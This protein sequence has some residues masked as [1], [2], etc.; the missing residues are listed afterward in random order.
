MTRIFS[1][2]ARRFTDR[3]RHRSLINLERLEPRIAMDGDG[4]VETNISS[5]YEYGRAIEL[6]ADGQL[7]A[8]GFAN[9]VT[10]TKGN[11]TISQN[12]GV[13]VRY[14]ADGSLDSALS[15]DGIQTT[16]L[17]STQDGF[18]DLAI[19][20]DQKIVAAGYAN[21]NNGQMAVVRYLPN[22][23]LDPSFDADGKAFTSFPGGGRRDTHVA[24]QGFAVGLQP[25][26]KIVV[27][28]RVWNFN[29]GSWRFG[30]ARFN[31]NGS[32]DTTFA[33]TGHVITDFGL[34][35]VGTD[36][37]KI[38]YE[39][40]A[41]ALQGDGKIIAAGGGV[42][43]FLM[44]RYNADGTL[45]HSFDGD[46]LIV[47]DVNSTSGWGLIGDVALQ[48]DGK[49]V[50]V[51]G[52]DF[53]AQGI[54]A[55]YNPDGSLDSAFG[56]G[57]LVQHPHF[58]G[59]ITNVELQSDGKIV[60][61]GLRDWRASRLNADGSLDT[62]FAGTGS[63]LIASGSNGADLVIQPN[64]PNVPHDDKFVLIAYGENGNNFI[65]ARLNSDGAF[66]STWGDSAASASSSSLASTE[67]TVAPPPAGGS[68]SIS[69]LDT[70]A[71][72]QLFAEPEAKN[73]WTR[74]SRFKL[75][76]L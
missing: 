66:D 43:Y 35:L 36:G 2:S 21:V 26:Q 23:S 20:G 24:A 49:I 28:G 29:T 5:S 12:D 37:Q 41:V 45:D 9:F 10:T 4:I 58:A 15:G 40:T 19:Q 13:L 59:T 8:A 17:G 57:G 18:W 65:V 47:R 69:A 75:F 54:V 71:V 74:K 46:G 55:R 31:S 67:T 51:G 62:P 25:D 22:G 38:H 72:Q 64:D 61:S 50:V 30:V 34:P 44:A 48:P 70:A 39:V 32:L 42:G 6:Q 14:N 27:A 60:V 53:T 7:V 1:H 56:S 68:R 63:V 76:A 33:G 3:I 11:K 52:H 73:T 16:D